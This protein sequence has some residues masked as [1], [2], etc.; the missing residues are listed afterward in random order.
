MP[1]ESTEVAPQ[2]NMVE[3]IFRYLEV[4][5][6]FEI[7]LLRGM[8]TTATDQQFGLAFHEARERARNEL[9]IELITRS[10]ERPG[11]YFRADAEQRLNRGANF[12]R[13]ANRKL[14]RAMRVIDA[15]PAEELDAAQFAQAR[16]TVDRAAE[17]VGRREAARRQRETEQS[18]QPTATARP[19]RPPRA[20]HEPDPP[21]WQR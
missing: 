16:R 5:S 3:L 11:F 12:I 20:A 13:T 14:L 15:I 10:F 4:H 19:A 17:Q 1:D 8:F 6:S 2:F 18:F 9:K 21:P 7:S